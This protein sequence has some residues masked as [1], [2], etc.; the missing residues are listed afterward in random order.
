MMMK[1]L[2]FSLI[3]VTAFAAVL[4]I[5]IA[6]CGQPN[7][8]SE[9]PKSQVPGVAATTA[10][11]SSWDE[12]VKAAQKEGTVDIYTTTVQVAVQPL[13]QAFKQKYGINLQFVTGVPTEVA[14]KLISERNAGL[15]LA[16]VV[17]IG[18][19]IPVM[20]WRP[21]GITTPLDDFLVLPE[22][23]DPKNW[24][25]GALPFLDKDHHVL[26]FAAQAYPQTVVNT[27]LL[28]EGAYSSFVDFTKPEWKDRIVLND[29]AVTG[30]GNPIFAVMYKV[31]GKERALQLFK[32]LAANNPVVSRDNR[33][34]LEWVAR[35]KYPLGIGQS[36]SLYP[37]FQ[38]A[39][40]PIRTVSLKEPRHVSS[41]A[42]TVTVLSKYPHPNA[43]KLNI[44]WILGKEGSTIWARELQFPS[45]RVDVKVDGLDPDILPKAGDIFPNEDHLKLRVEMRQVGTDI[46]GPLMR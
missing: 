45:T 13:T 3:A 12:L 5:L 28:K 31:F 42:G 27:D 22:V 40:A 9:Q 46:F 19:T 8:A 29:P 35:G 14:V 25:G 17:H 24:I 1:K 26:M 36:M 2:H 6:G 18:E 44:N 33:I 10:P 41:G 30:I 4:A 39:G 15:Y 43:A 21:L 34:L 38:R 16:D 23:K 32:Q 37:E 11:A 7:V 20:D